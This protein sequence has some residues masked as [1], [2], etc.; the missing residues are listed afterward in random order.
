MRTAVVALALLLSGCRAG[1]DHHRP[2]SPTRAGVDP[3]AL[4][5]PLTADDSQSLDMRSL[6]GVGD[7]V[8]QRIRPAVLPPKR[9]VLCLSGGGC[10]GAYSAG[11][12]CGWTARG[13]R[14]EFDVVTGIS[15]GALIAPFA[16][17]GPDGDDEVRALFTTVRSRDIYRTHYARGLVSESFASN[18]PLAKRL[19]QEVNCQL[20]NRIAA[21]HARGRRLYI[22]TTE[23]EGKRFVVWDIGAIASRGTPADADLIVR[24]LLGSTAI[25]GFFPPEDIPV[26][27]NGRQF[28]EQHVDGGV[29]QTLFFRPPYTPPGATPALYGTDVYAV[30]AGKLYA[31][32]GP[33]KPRAL[34]VTAEAAS[35]VLYAQGRGDLTR[36][37][38]VCELTGMRYHST[39]IPRDY[40]APKSS[41]EFDPGVMTGMFEEGARQ[42]L[43]GTVWRT[44]PPGAGPG[45]LPDERAGTELILRTR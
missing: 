34:R 9:S 11:V 41:T 32:P 42:V 16:F 29:S 36:L 4:D 31:D 2:P 18:D 28:V 40:P 23:L 10:Y 6:V 27:V 7:A 19:R 1:R 38:T 20:V 26:T 14:P 12:L 5:D 22:G 3:R 35:A 24:V 15:T 33:V 8:R 30:V 43:A 45:E 37:W 44:T 21:E 25:P 39:A 13:D 17:I